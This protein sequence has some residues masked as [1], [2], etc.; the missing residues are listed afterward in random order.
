MGESKDQ[1]PEQ[2][3]HGLRRLRICLMLTGFKVGTLSCDNHLL[4]EPLSSSGCSEGCSES[5]PTSVFSGKI[6]SDSTGR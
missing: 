1:S 6:H 2:S 4:A 3:L 5:A